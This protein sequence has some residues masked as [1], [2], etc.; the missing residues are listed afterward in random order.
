MAKDYTLDLNYLEQLADM[1]SNFDDETIQDDYYRVRNYIDRLKNCY[2]SKATSTPLLERLEIDYGALDFFKPFYPYTSKLAKTS[3]QTH[4]FETKKKYRKLEISTEAAINILKD[5]FK[6]QGEFFYKQFIEYL[7]EIEGHFEYVEP[8]NNMDG[9]MLFLSSVGE[10][11]VS[12][13]NYPNI[14]KLAIT[15]HEITHV[16]DCFNNP[17]LYRNYMVREISTVFMEII[18]SDYLSQK[19]RL[20]NDNIKRRAYLHSIIKDKAETIVN[21]TKMLRFYGKYKDTKS[22]NLFSALKSKGFSKEEIDE[23]EEECLIENYFYIIAQLTAIELYFI[24]KKDKEK[25]LAI[26]EDII[27]NATDNNILN[28]LQNHGIILTSNLD[29]YEEEL[30]RGLKNR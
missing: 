21:K 10:A 3:Y 2:S 7:E 13:V 16:T 27:M 8:N 25:A 28:I 18:A 9:E 15:A 17:E 19:L 11:F 26:L 1:F 4:E 29:A 12:V 20:G 14:C 24:Y 23:L 30:I 5:F 6:E 22:K